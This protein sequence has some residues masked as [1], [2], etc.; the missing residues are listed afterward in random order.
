MT[1]PRPLPAIDCDNRAYWTG[2][3]NG[4]LLI[5][6]CAGC[7]TFIHPPVPF[8]PQCEGR[9][10]APQPVSGRGRVH[11]FTIN[12]K[13]WVPGL[14]ERYVLALVAIEEQADV[15]LPC[16]IVNCDP[17]D[18][19]FDMTVKVLFEQHEDLWVPLFEPA[20]D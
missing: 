16:N 3:R 14:P 20:G 1:L 8:C 12:Y 13:Q 19:R 18:V 10:V 7:S 6:R 9:D 15:L 4:E 5:Y 11:T 17:D 2:G